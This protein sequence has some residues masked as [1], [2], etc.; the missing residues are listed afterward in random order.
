[1]AAFASHLEAVQ[2]TAMM[3]VWHEERDPS[4]LTFSECTQLRGELGSGGGG[5]GGNS[6]S[7]SRLVGLAFSACVCCSYLGRFCC[8]SLSD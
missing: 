2:A 7:S 8:T 1:M 3:Q 5:G 6:K 4:N